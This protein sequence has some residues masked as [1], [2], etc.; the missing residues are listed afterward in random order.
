[1]KHPAPSVSLPLEPAR[2]ILGD[3]WKEEDLPVEWDRILPGGALHLEV[4][5]GGGE[6]LLKRAEADP[7]G[8]YIGVDHFAEGHRRLIAAASERG[9]GNVLSVVGDAFVVVNLLFADRSLESC[10]INFPDPWP[11]ARHA[12]RRLFQ[13]EFF[14]IVARKLAPQGLLYLATD[15]RPYALEAAE[16]WPKVPLLESTHPKVPWLEESPHPFTTRYE[17][18]WKSE[19]RALH[20]FVLRRRADAPREV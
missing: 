19:G 15:D 8:R 12:R 20:Y 4:G 6:F 14:R 7:T 11:K 9:I 1:M 5:F 18:R 10:T 13:E 3:W 2:V 16:E 17:E